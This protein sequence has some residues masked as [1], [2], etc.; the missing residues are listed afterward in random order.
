MQ[1]EMRE[2]HFGDGVI[3][4]SEHNLNQFIKLMSDMNMVYPTYES[5]KLHS[6]NAKTFCY[7]WITFQFL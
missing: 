1:K 5:L 2:F 6:A 4:K 7:R 3:E